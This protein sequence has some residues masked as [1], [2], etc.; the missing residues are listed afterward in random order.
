MGGGKERRL[1][2]WL[3]MLFFLDRDWY[4]SHRVADGL[5]GGG[6]LIGRV[7]KAARLGWS[8]GGHFSAF[9]LPTHNSRSS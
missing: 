2:S 1:V 9:A 7:E 6:G 3:D 5:L 4:M 8:E